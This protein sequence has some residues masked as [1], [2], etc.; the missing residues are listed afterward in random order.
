MDDRLLVGRARQ[1]DEVAFETLVRRHADTVWRFARTMVRDDHDAEE[2]VQ[3]TFV[4]AYRGLS[5]YRGDAAITTWLYSICRRTALDRARR[6]SSVVVPIESARSV[7]AR[8]ASTDDRVAIEAAL[9]TLPPD[10]RE[11]FTLVAVLGYSQEE[12][13]TLVGIPAST[14]RSR[15]GRA[16]T[17]L[18]AAV[19]VEEDEAQ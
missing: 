8:S 1:G 4:K 15:M 5:S 6:R 7:P 9:E 13:A 3:D 2:V 10:D 14:M 12:A 18:A 19:A 11:A 16:R 17:R